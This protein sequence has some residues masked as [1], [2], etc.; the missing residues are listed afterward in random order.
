M[1][2]A[3]T[4]FKVRAWSDFLADEPVQVSFRKGQAFYVLSH[5]LKTN[6]Y[7]VSTQFSTPFSR[8]AVNGLVPADLFN[9]ED[10]YASKSSTAPTKK[11][12]KASTKITNPIANDKVSSALITKH[13]FTSNSSLPRFQ[14]RVVRHQYTHIVSRSFDDFIIVHNSLIREFPSEFAQR[15]IPT[16][17]API[18]NVSDLKRSGRLDSRIHQQTQQLMI[19]LNNLFQISPSFVINSAPLV[20]FLTPRDDYEIKTVEHRKDKKQVQ[21]QSMHNSTSKA[22]MKLQN[23]FGIKTHINTSKSMNTDAKTVE[24]LTK[25][26]QK[27]RFGNKNNAAAGNPRLHLLNT[28]F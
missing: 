15:L 4:I 26:F 17:P 12:N 24:N 14:I 25:S 6:M 20:K 19:Y 21:P 5:D 23:L 2:E 7:F 10:L 11:S 27:A 3:T 1:A 13:T 16:L 8:T 22:S 28:Y 9:I 18:T